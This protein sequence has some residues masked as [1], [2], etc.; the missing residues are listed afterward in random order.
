MTSM[1]GVQWSFGMSRN[2]YNSTGPGTLGGGSPRRTIFLAVLAGHAIQIATQ[3]IDH[4]VVGFEGHAHAG[5]AAKAIAL[6]HHMHHAR[7]D[8][9]VGI[10]QADAQANLRAL[11]RWRAVDN[12]R[13]PKRQ[14]NHSGRPVRRRIDQ[15]DHELH[16]MPRETLNAFVPHKPIVP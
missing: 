6:A 15:I 12:A 4:A 7:N 3:H 16:P 5:R 10:G 14:I 13:A 8:G 1:V 11:S 9:D 2:A